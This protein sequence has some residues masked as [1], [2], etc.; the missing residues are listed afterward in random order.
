LD[1]DIAI[2]LRG[3]DFEVKQADELRKKYKEDSGVET[4]EPGDIERQVSF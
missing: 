1:F 2:A 3:I 4:Y